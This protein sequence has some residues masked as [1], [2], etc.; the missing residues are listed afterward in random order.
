MSAARPSRPAGGA[1]E[2]PSGASWLI[3]ESA[4]PS[5]DGTWLV[6]T[7]PTEQA[8]REG[9]NRITKPTLWSQIAGRATAFQLEPERVTV[10]PVDTFEF[11][12][13]EPLTPRNLRLIAANWL[14]TNVLPYALLIILGCMGLGLATHFLVGQ[15]GR[16]S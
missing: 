13:T 12:T 3:T 7:A 4:N 16:R 5:G 9:T 2:P 14:S 6:V 11:V 10:Q 15:L 8:L 1:Y